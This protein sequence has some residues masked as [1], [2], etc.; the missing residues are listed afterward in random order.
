MKAVI[1]AGGFGTRLAE[2]T[3]I[4]PKPLVD[5]GG[6]PILWHIMKHC[7]RHGFSEFFIALGYRGEL[8]KRYFLDYYELAGDMTISLADGPRRAHHAQRENWIIHLIDT[9]HSSQTGG[10]VKR[11]QEWLADDTFFVTYGDGVSN[12]DLNALVQYHRSSGL[13]GTVT[14]VR[15][16]ARFGGIVFDGSRVAT[17]MEKPQIGEGWINGG[18]M[19]FEPGVFEYLEGD[20]S[21]LETDGLERMAADQQLAAFRHEGYWQCMDTLRDVRLLR[22][23]WESG[24]APWR[25]WE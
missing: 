14:A 22:S 11:L 17:F 15:P 8:I 3:D 18:F 16:P 24:H 21:V 5:I 6:Q 25:T 2:E 1:L 23:T 4:Q 10:R 19:I 13:M 7:A 20:Q 9:G 12:V